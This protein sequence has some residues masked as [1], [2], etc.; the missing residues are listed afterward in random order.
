MKLQFENYLDEQGKDLVMS[1]LTKL[2]RGTVGQLLN[3]F[4]KM[5]AN[6]VTPHNYKRFKG[7]DEGIQFGE[8][9]LGDFRVL[10][11]RRSETSFVLL[12]LFR[13]QANET[14]PSEKDKAYQRLLNYLSRKKP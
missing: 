11:Y 8:L 6:G 7:Y 14:P 13:K 5:Q 3:K 4:E 1:E 10:V 9:I 12:R 2:D